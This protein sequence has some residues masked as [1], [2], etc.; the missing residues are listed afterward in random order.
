MD[1]CPER[2]LEVERQVDQRRGGTLAKR[3]PPIAR[4]EPCLMP[5]FTRLA[6]RVLP[7]LCFGRHLCP[8]W[9]HHEEFFLRSFHSK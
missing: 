4:D 9:V 1:A 6:E 5:L 2:R 3:G 8:V 7:C